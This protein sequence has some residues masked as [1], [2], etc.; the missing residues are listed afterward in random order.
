[1][2]SARA[3]LFQLA[4]LVRKSEDDTVVVFEA[5]GGAEG[6][7]LV[8]ESRLAFL[9][10]HAA[11]T[12]PAAVPFTVAGSLT[13]DLDDEALSASLRELRAEWGRSG[14]ARSPGGGAA[15]T[16]AAARPRPRRPRRQ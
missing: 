8:R 3:R 14:I 10:D 6:V 12:A 13:T 7:A 5:R 1:M 4:D 16:K 15:K 11:R 2:S 9:E